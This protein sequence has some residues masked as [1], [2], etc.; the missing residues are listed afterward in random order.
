MEED[1]A[2]K[3][4][5]EKIVEAYN[6]IKE[7][8]LEIMVLDQNKKEVELSMKERLA[9]LEGLVDKEGKPAASKIKAGLLVKAIDTHHTGE[10]KLEADLST[11]EGYLARIKNK[12]VPKSQVDRF[13]MLTDEG[14]EAKSSLTNIT[15][16]LKDTLDEDIIKAIISVANEEVEIEKSKTED[17]D[18]DS[19]KKQQNKA[20]EILKKFYTICTEVKKMVKR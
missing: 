17:S 18:T 3:Y 7:V 10:N 13:I 12:E 1:L 19:E 2:K 14:K 11:M 4:P 9:D 20:P 5:K 16:S 8:K 15:K 6:A